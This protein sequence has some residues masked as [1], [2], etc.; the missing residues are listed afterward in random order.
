MRVGDGCRSLDLFTHVLDGSGERVLNI[1]NVGPLREWKGDKQ[2]MSPSQWEPGKIYVDE[3]DFTVPSTLRTDKIQV[4]TGIW[5]ENDRMK[6]VGGPADRE[7]RG[8]V[9]NISTGAPAAPPTPEPSTRVP[10]L[11]VDKLEKGVKIS[12]DGKLD[13]PAWATAPGTG[14]FI[15]VRTG[16]PSAGFPVSGSVKLLW[17][18]QNL[19]LA[20]DVKDPDI[21][22]GFDKKQKD[23]LDWEYLLRC[24]F[25]CRHCHHLPKYGTNLRRGRLPVCQQMMR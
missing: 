21:V 19:Y 5:R 7:N 22:S 23:L 1:D 11:R 25:R 12:L 8:I 4:T 10:S 15:D 16:R 13:E 3:Q 14:P 20:F 2:V 9:A 18:D 17:D 24:L 6:I